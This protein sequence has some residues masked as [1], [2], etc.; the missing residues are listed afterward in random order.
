MSPWH[1]RSVF[2]TGCTGFLGSWLT[3][4][5]VQRGARVVGLVRDHV[6]DD[7][8]ARMGLAERITVVRGAVEDLGLLER[9]VNEYDVD[10]VFH[11]AAQAIVGV[12]NRSPLATFETNILGTWNVLEACRRSG[13][14]SRIVVASSDKAY[15][16]HD[17]L[18]YR[19]DFPLQGCHPYDVSKS[20]ADLIARSYHHTYG[21]PICVTRCGNLFGEGDTNYSRIVP[22]TIRSMLQG[23]RPIIRSDGSP[24]REYVHV[25]DIVDGYLVLAE[26]MEDAALHGEAFNLG[27][28]EYLS[29]ADLTRRI[30]EL[31]GRNDLEPVI[32][33]EVRAEIPHQYLSSEKAHRL[34][35]WQPGADVQARLKQTIEWYQTVLPTCAMS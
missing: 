8:F 29:V 16:I 27:S 24:V 25:Q 21:L 26:R 32:L 4:E 14:A 7:L 13:R 3:G 30:L 33:D 5:L 23:E 11:L 12:A 6:P 35:Q 19:E 20:C 9:I 17:E 34:L 18:P 1:D 2:V 22:G 31:G 10:V 15:G 28:G